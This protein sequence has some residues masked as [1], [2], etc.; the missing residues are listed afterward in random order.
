[1]RQRGRRAVY[2]GRRCGSVYA[3][4]LAA[5]FS[6]PVYRE[7]STASAS[8]RNVVSVIPPRV[9][10]FLPS[11][12][13]PSRRPGKT[14]SN[15]ILALANRAKYIYESRECLPFLRNVYPSR[16]R[17]GFNDCLPMGGT[18]SAISGFCLVVTE[19]GTAGGFQMPHNAPFSL[20]LIARWE[21]RTRRTIQ[22]PHFHHQEIDWP[23][24]PVASAAL[25]AEKR[26]EHSDDGP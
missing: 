11:P 18:F 15:P 3:V 7:L 23:D 6:L 4:H 2:G 24:E 21:P 9:L 22:P 14:F 13:T 12:L 5:G 10:F 17:G 16:L 19:M 26:T 20:K 25:S 8:V 1:M